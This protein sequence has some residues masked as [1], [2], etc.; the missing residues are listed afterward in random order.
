MQW[1]NRNE[2]HWTAHQQ[3]KFHTSLH[4]PPVPILGLPADECWEEHGRAS[5]S[6]FVRINEVC[7]KNAVVILQ[8]IGWPWTVF[9]AWRQAETK[10]SRALWATAGMTNFAARTFELKNTMTHPDTSWH[11]LQCPRHSHQLNHWSLWS[12]LI[13]VGPLKSG[14]LPRHLKPRSLN[15]GS[16]K[17]FASIASAR[18]TGIRW[19]ATWGVHGTENALLPPDSSLRTCRLVGFKGP[20]DWRMACPNLNLTPEGSQECW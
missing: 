17:C 6:L 2:Q 13:P 10:F 16:P 12:S 19:P 3:L 20:A 14:H 11:S 15:P 8:E 5:N 1:T 9:G 4:R 18:L 7:V